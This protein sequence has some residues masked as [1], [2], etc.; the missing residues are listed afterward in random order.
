M[1]VKCTI[2]NVLQKLVVSFKYRIQ[3]INTTIGKLGDFFDALLTWA[4][5]DGDRH[6][7]E[8]L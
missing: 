5:P 8:V 7:F 6:I 3:P 1:Q 2:M 4:T